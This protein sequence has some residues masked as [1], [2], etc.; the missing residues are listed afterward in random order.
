MLSGKKILGASQRRIKNNF[1]H[2]ST[3]FFQEAP[4]KIIQGI[5][6]GFESLWKVKFQTKPLNEE[7]LRQARY[8]EQKRY[9][10]NDWANPT[11]EQAEQSLDIK[12][13]QTY[14][15]SCA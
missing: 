3:M 10:S 11:V 6:N 2:Q 8:L 13:Q 4:E 1:L 12:K 9:G 15:D 7:E 14:I 5:L